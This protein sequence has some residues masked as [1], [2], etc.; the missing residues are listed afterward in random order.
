MALS[1]GIPTGDWGEPAPALGASLWRAWRLLS[2]SLA[3]VQAL[4]SRGSPSSHLHPTLG[5][6]KGNHGSTP[7]RSQAPTLR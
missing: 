6:R 1:S 7:C 3:H 5:W 2:G 4:L